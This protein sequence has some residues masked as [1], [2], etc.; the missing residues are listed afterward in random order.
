MAFLLEFKMNITRFV[1]IKKIDDDE[2]MVYGWAST[3]D[4]DKDGEIIEPAAFEKSLPDY[5]KFPTIREMHQ[6]K[7]IG[8]TKETR[9]EKDRGLFIAAKIVD[10][11]AWMKVKEGVYRAFS[12]GGRV[13]N[14]ID[15]VIKE[16]ELIEISLVDVPA[17]PAAV[18]TLFKGDK[19]DNLHIE[20]QQLANKIRSLMEEKE[21]V[22]ADEVVEVIN[23]TE[24]VEKA[25]VVEKMTEEVQE[26]EAEAAEVAEAVE[27]EVV[28]EVKTAEVETEKVESIDVSKAY[29]AEIAK[30][31]TVVKELSTKFES[32]SERL[33]KLETM[34]NEPK[35]KGSFVAVPEVDANESGNR[36]G[37]INKRLTEL[38][39]M[40]EKDMQAYQLG[41][42]SIEAMKLLSEK[43]SL[44]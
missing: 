23:N 20:F 16:L 32:L 30:F 26:L 34:P 2:R 4:L 37:V 40:R 11:E 31:D 38:M 24:A 27:E 19:T 7:P 12:I 41:N 18:I 36:L 5:L 21:V 22:T 44:E 1:D 17:N 8:I 33:A 28:E 3:G 25:D 39:E 14:R 43:R 15:N 13:K 29:E 9:M 35:T 6:P 10:S 42:Y